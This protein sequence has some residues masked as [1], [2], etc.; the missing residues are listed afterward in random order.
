M[1]VT[2][3][4]DREHIQNEDAREMIGQFLALLG[5]LGHAG[6]SVFMRQAAFHTKETATSVFVNILLGTIVFSLVLGLSGNVS[7]LT[8]ASWQAL[9][10]LAGAGIVVFVLGRR[11]NYYSLKLIG[12]NRGSPLLNSSTLV[13][14]TLGITLMGER[15]TLGLALGVCFIV[16]GVVLVS[17]ERS[18][19]GTPDSATTKGDLVK[20]VA[21]GISAGILYGTGPVLAK[22]AIEEGNSPF[23]GLFISY[24]AALLLM[25][26]PRLLSHKL[27]ES[28]VFYRKAIVPMSIGAASSSIAQLFRYIALGYIS[29]SVVVPLNSTATLFTILLSFIINRRIELFTLKII[30]GAILVVGGVFLIFQ[31]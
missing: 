25:L 27:P 22:I 23:T 4:T 11:L 5:G 28:I 21:A 2:I 30:V 17:T 10:A 31:L 13:A 8:T 6:N 20:G 29:V 16:I 18:D 19:S 24:V 9:A 3:W 15:F 1:L 26:V 7:Q 12:A 14:V